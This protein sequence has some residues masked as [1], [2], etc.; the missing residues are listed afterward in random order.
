MG[1]R[2]EA[3]SIVQCVAKRRRQLERLEFALEATACRLCSSRTTKR[4]LCSAKAQIE[5][6]RSYAKLLFEALRKEDE[7]Q[8]GAQH[9]F[10][11]AIPL[12]V[13]CGRQLD[14]K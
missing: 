9:L 4:S 13:L 7:L 12:E 8:L 14:A 1:P 10:A 2:D 3:L 11:S 6:Q 5:T